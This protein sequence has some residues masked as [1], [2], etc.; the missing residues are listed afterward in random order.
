MGWEYSTDA[1]ECGADLP[2]VTLQQQTENIYNFS[3]NIYIVYAI[4][5]VA[6][7]SQSACMGPISI[8]YACN[9]CKQGKLALIVNCSNI[10]HSA[11]AFENRMFLHEFFY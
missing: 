6:N 1:H 4:I 11:Q 10:K 2:P 5:A 9:R 8:K 7:C 3:S